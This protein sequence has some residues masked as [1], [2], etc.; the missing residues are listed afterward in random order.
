M[1]IKTTFLTA[2]LVIFGGGVAMKTVPADVEPRKGTVGSYTLK[3]E[4]RDGKC[5]LLYEGP[6][7]GQITLEIPPPCEFSRDNLGKLQRHQYKRKRNAGV[8]DVILVVGG[9]VTKEKSD[10][11]MQDGCG[12]QLQAVSLSS[13][14]VALGG[15]LSMP[16]ACPMEGQDEMVFGILNKPI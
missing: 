1:I 7:K 8:Y 12:T 11:L 9:P 6:H 15:H 2:V 16:T 13:R 10:K 5:Q 3:L 14:G 4:E